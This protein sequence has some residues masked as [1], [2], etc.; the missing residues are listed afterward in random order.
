MRTPNNF[1]LNPKDLLLLVGESPRFNLVLDEMREGRATAQELCHLLWPEID[2]LVPLDGPGIR[3][4]TPLAWMTAVMNHEA[5]PCQL[6]GSGMCRK[7]G[8]DYIYFAGD[9]SSR[10]RPTHLPHWTSN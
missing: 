9:T 6:G 8:E 5:M 4:M 1:L 3:G 7:E 2:P 10:P